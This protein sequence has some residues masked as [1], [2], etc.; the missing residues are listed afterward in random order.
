M[1]TA[2]DCGSALIYVFVQKT[3]D[4]AVEPFYFEWFL[5]DRS[6]VVIREFPQ[7]RDK[8]RG[9]RDGLAQTT[10]QPR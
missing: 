2:V 10:P 1:K 4:T 9:R 8:R 3:A 5:K 6:E 7:F